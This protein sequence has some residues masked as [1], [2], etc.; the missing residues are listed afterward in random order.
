MSRHSA[1]ALGHTSAL[2]VKQS[3][4]TDVDTPDTRYDNTPDTRYGTVGVDGTHYRVCPADA[5][6]LG[7]LVRRRHRRPW[8]LYT[9][10]G[11]ELPHRPTHQNRHVAGCVRG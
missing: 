3:A 5:F 7:V 1:D 11:G 10:R 4:C 6:V 8:G 9:N 2:C